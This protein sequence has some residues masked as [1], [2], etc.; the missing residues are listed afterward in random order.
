M[1]QALQGTGTHVLLASVRSPQVVEQAAA[2]GVRHVTANPDVVEA[3][4]ADE[5]TEQAAR[6]FEDVMA[7]RG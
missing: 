5:H 1:V 3:M 6:V 2:V 7:R 4:A